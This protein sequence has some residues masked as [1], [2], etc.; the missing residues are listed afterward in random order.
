MP[1]KKRCFASTK[2]LRRL[3][4]KVL[5]ELLGHFRE[6]VESKGLAL[7]PPQEATAVNLDYGR[8]RDV[9]MAGDIPHEL[10]DVLFHVCA[11][12][13]LEGWDK[14]QREA[15][16]QKNRLDF[17]TADLSFADLAIKA[18]LW[19]W[20]NNRA[21][22][23]QSYAR[24]KIHSRSSY[25]YYPAVKGLRQPYRPPTA[26]GLD[27]VRAEL[28]EYFVG[29]A[30]GKGTSLLIYDYEKE[31]W[32]LIRYPG[33]LERHEAIGVDGEVETPVFK[34]AEYDAVVY[35]KDY[36]DLRLNTNR[37][38]EHKKY[39]I[40]FGNLLFGTG[41][42][43]DP[44]ERI[45]HLEPL[46]GECRDIFKC[47]DV[48]GLGSIAPI[49]VGFCSLA[50]PGREM[51]WRSEPDCSL[52]DYGGSD[53]RLL[54]DDTHSVAYAKFRYRRKDRVKH[55]TV[56]VHTGKTLNYERDGDSAVLEQW[57]RRR[58]FIRGIGLSMWTALLGWAAAGSEWAV[59]GIG[60]WFMA[61]G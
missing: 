3:D 47:E 15:E 28:A 32:F 60:E 24:A 5:V 61:Y 14:I 57:L 43:F 2:A 12:G 20:P 38:K 44:V 13:S 26:A 55:D 54:P 46:K 41:N 25:V 17:R 56:T 37:A 36:R 33:Q 1:G 4:P 11:L 22:L 59:G 42:A 53:E 29:E 52:L 23:E 51:V 40:V 9:C 10:D 7:P 6:Y 30:L 34:P 27:G 50:A 39:R 58:G 45:V 8:L 31:T 18:W 49:E 19:D 35:H 48:P 21:L 16:F